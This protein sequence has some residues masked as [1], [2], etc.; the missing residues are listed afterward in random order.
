MANNAAITASGIIGITWSAP[1]SNG[2]SAIIDYKISYKTGTAAYSVL[3]SGITATSYTASSLSAGVIY[4][5]KVTARNAVGLGAD[6][7]EVSIIAATRP[8]SP[9]SLA[10][11]AAITAAGIVGIA[12]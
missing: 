2:G 4:N 1:S 8:T 12:W 10:N 9:Q 6:S 5:F 7:S 3:A 11:N